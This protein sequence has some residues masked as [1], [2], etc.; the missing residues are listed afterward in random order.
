MVLYITRFIFTVC[1]IKK[2]AKY[3]LFSNL[4]T[5]V[6]ILLDSK[7]RKVYGSQ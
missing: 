2:I 1:T 5:K 3:N 7:H 6:E 4:Y